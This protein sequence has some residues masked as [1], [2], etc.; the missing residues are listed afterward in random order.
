MPLVNVS[1]PNLF[2]GVSQQADEFRFP[3]Q[4]TE[5]INAYSSIVE[6]LKKRA[7]LEHVSRLIAGQADTTGFVKILNFSDSKQFLLYI[8]GNATVSMKIFDLSD[9]TEK[10]IK[11][12]AGSAI[13][14]GD[15]TYLGVTADMWKNLAALPVVDFLFIVNKTTTVA[16]QSTA[17]VAR[18]PEALVFCKL[19]ANSYDYTIQLFNTVGATSPSYTGSFTGAAT[20]NQA[21]VIAG[22]VSSLN[23]AGAGSIYTLISEGSNLHIKRGASGD[24]FR[25][26]VASS[27]PEAIFAFKDRAQS[28][29]VLPK[30]GYAG[31]E[32]SI[33]GDADV[34][35]D[36]FYIKFEAASDPTL[37]DVF[38]E[39]SWVETSKKGE[40]YQLDAGTMPHVLV[41]NTDDTFSFLEETWASRVAGDTDSNPHPLFVNEK[42]RDIFFFKNRLGLISS[43]SISLSEADNFF[44]YYRNSVIDLLDADSI[45]VSSNSN[46]LSIFNHATPFSEKLVLSSDRSQ[47]TLEGREILT[48]QTI[49][50]TQST[51]YSFL[52]DTKPVSI[53]NKLFFPFS[54]GEYS[55]LFE[56]ALRSDLDVFEAIDT[57]EAVPNYMKGNIK[58]MARETSEN[59]LVIHTDNPEEKNII[60]IYKFLSKGGERVQQSWSSF[61]LG[62]DAE[63]IGLDFIDTKLYVLL[64]R[65]DNTYLEKM[66]FASGITDT[67]SNTMVNLDRKI[68]ED[69]CT[70]I[71]FNAS[72]EETTMTLPYEPLA[73]SSIVVTTRAGAVTTDV[74]Q[75]GG[76]SFSG[77]TLTIPGD[78]SSTDLWIGLTYE[79][80]YTMTRPTIREV[81]AG[82]SKVV[83]NGRFQLRYGSVSFDDS[84][85]FKVEVVPSVG[86]T[87]T[88]TYAGSTLDTSSILNSTI[89]VSD[90]VFTFPIFQT[91]TD[92]TITLK[93]SSP[94]PSNFLGI[95]W[96]GYYNSKT[97]RI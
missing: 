42:I 18:N 92:V 81:S 54:R 46:E 25:V 51:N 53:G 79:L 63:V 6:G 76:V 58:A 65:H 20:S 11:N 71:S 90:G 67:L 2:N 15:L 77:T 1:V 91:N 32:I 10:T 82:S 66:D 37:T 17:S 96:E 4:A 55:G 21:D 8:Y 23:S 39:G 41:K 48:A 16:A 3:S 57:S 62:A 5:Q 22:L 47:F 43:E 14:S 83:K 60:Y 93:N 29:A 24:D 45:N 88:Y 95:D 70:S 86:Y 61:D 52:P 13:S 38:T 33:D 72:T 12:S 49:S 34:S 31:F 69:E 94:F 78:F 80:E 27:A 36:T 84:T 9:G 74:R 59:L 26:N 35:D 28:V 75:I 30:K 85:T 87:Y 40:T 44:T 68:T 19:A 89:N 73:G 56:Y 97:R 7:P 64:N 50:I